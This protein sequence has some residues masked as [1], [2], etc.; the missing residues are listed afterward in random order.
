MARENHTKSLTKVVQ[1][2]DE[3]VNDTEALAVA[4]Q[5]IEAIQAGTGYMA[6]AM[7][8]ATL[9]HRKLPDDVIV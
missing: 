3:P 5:E 4:Q 9:P 1:K 2:V 7:V 6:R 8:L